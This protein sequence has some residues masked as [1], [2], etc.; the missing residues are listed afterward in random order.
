MCTFRDIWGIVANLWPLLPTYYCNVVSNLLKF[1]Y[2]LVS[3]LENEMATGCFNQLPP[4]V[5]FP[6]GGGG[7]SYLV[8]EKTEKK[9][10]SIW[11]QNMALYCNKWYIYDIM[12]NF[13]AILVYC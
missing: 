1:P 12:S 9:T 11:H 3:I 13:G 7:Q 8:R 4:P 5:P 2:Y 10:V 6:R